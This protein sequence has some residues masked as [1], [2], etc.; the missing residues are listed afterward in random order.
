MASSRIDTSHR[1]SGKDIRFWKFR[2]HYPTGLKRSD[3][4]LMQ[5]GRCEKTYGRHGTALPR[6]N[7]QTGEIDPCNNYIFGRRCMGREYT[8]Y[9]VIE[10]EAMPI[11]SVRLPTK[12]KEW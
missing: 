6:I 1:P 5:C 7:D 4:V 10:V 3:T 8:I 12:G 9:D 11:G 2:S